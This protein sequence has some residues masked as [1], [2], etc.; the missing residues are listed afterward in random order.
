MQRGISLLPHAISIALMRQPSTRTGGTWISAIE[1]LGGK[2]HLYSGMASSAEAKGESLEDSYVA[3]A[4]QSDIIGIRTKEEDGP[5]VAAR[6]I[7]KAFRD[8]KLWQPVPVVNLGNG[9]DEHT[10]QAMGDAFTLAKW[11]KYEPLSGKIMA[12]V[13][14]HERY[15]A[16]HSELLIAKRLGIYVIAVQSE[17]APVPQNIVEEMGDSIELTS[18]LDEAMREAHILSVGRNPDEYDGDDPLELERSRML[19]EQYEQWIIDYERLQQMRPDAIVKHPR[20]RRNELNPSVDSDPRMWDIEQM[21]SMVPMRMAITARH[22]G[23]S[24]SE[25]ARLDIPPARRAIIGT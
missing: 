25:H 16:H 15:R 5:Y 23:V 11:N 21:S 19:A 24:I 1:K 10:S 14:D 22:L 17:V 12:V 20:P 18:D 9:T 4:T 2:G 8:G 3:L 7:A 13:G 6:A